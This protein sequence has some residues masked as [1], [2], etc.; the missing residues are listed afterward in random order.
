[1]FIVAAKKDKH[2]AKSFKSLVYCIN[3]PAG[4]DTNINNNNNNK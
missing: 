2:A 4:S 3:R 1:M